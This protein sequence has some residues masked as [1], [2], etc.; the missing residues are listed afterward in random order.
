M[1]KIKFLLTVIVVLAGTFVYVSCQNSEIEPIEEQESSQELK[2]VQEYRAALINLSNGVNS[3]SMDE[4][5]S[6]KDVET[7]VEV[8]REF[9]IQNDITSEDLGIEDEEILAV[10]AMALLDYQK[11]VVDQPISRTTAG[12]CVLEALGVREVVNAVGKGA[13]KKVAKVAA[14]AVLKKAIPYVGWGFFIYD[15]VACVVE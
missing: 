10:V 15:Y 13:A 5:P 6:Q 12:G 1:K 9:L 3:R 7:L 8:S 2:G 14:K 11:T 4:E